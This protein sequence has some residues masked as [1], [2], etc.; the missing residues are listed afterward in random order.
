MKIFDCHSHWATEKGY[1]FRTD[2]ERAQ[3]EKVWRTPFKLFT[4]QEQ[5]DYFRKNNVR[6]ILDISWIKELPL[7]EMREYH[8]YVIGV[9][10]QHR[11]VM[12][13][14][15]LQFLVWPVSLFWGLLV[16]VAIREVVQI[17]DP[18]HRV[19]RRRALLLRQTDAGLEAELIRNVAQSLL[20]GAIE[21]PRSRSN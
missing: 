4:E 14:Q 7:E 18:V 11:D 6:N 21:E 1:L 9:Q 17:A 12:F 16:F 10:R 3:Q 2:V 8:D 13:G 19:A 5:A 15:W 20:A